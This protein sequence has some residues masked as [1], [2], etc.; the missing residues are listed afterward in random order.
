MVAG[1]SHLDPSVTTTIARGGP[2]GTGA[3]DE[4]SGDGDGS[5]GVALAFTGLDVMALLL[6]GGA[7]LGLGVLMR[8]LATRPGT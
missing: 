2:D 3:D 6:A 8:R 1:Y 5:A 4:A 7:L